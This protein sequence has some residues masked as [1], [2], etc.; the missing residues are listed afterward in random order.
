MSK[1]LLIQW[2]ILLNCFTS[3]SQNRTED[4]EIALPEQ[5]VQNSLYNKISFLDSRDDT[6]YMGIVQLGAFNKKA[7]VI[8]KIPLEAQLR[9]VMSSLTDSTGKNGELLFQLRQFNFA[10]ITGA[11]NEKGYCYLKAA[12]YSKTRDQY[13]SISSIDTVILIKSMDVTRALFRNGSKVISNFIETNLLHEPGSLNYYSYNDVVNMDSIEKRS[14]AVYNIS[15]FSDGLYNTYTSFKN[16]TSDAEISVN[17]KDE[18][19]FSVKALDKM[20]KAVKVKA[21]DI[22]AIVYNGQPFIATEYGYYPLQKMNDDF[23]FTGRA[24]VTAK[25]GDVIAASFFFGIIGGLIASNSEAIFEMKID[26]SNGG[27]IRMKE[28]KNSN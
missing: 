27:F 19:I 24:K 26:H 16:Q 18:K 12:L 28:I 20:G 6:T 3:Y 21:K 8:S 22:Y 9:K 14:I 13:Q 1:S 25:T 2:F 23:F 17:M 5:K 7:K 11:V 15:K 4:F 10:E